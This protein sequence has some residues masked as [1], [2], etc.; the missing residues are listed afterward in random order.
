MINVFNLKFDCFIQSEN[1]MKNIYLM[2]VS[3]RQEKNIIDRTTGSEYCTFCV[4]RQIFKELAKEMNQEA[5]YFVF[6]CY[7]E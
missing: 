3:L 5:G 1:E 2:Y 7:D 4:W 6:L